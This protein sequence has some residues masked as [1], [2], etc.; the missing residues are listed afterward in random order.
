MPRASRSPSAPVEGSPSPS[1]SRQPARSL[2]KRLLFAAI[3]VGVLLLLLEG[4]ANVLWLLKDAQALQAD[5]DRVIGLK[6]DSHCQYD[7]EVGWVHIPGKHLEDFYGPGGSI[8]INDLGVRGTREIG[9]PKP[10]GRFRLVCLGDSFTLG[11]GVGD[12]ETFPEQLGQINAGLE[13]INMGQGG[14]SVGQCYLWYCQLADQL[15]AD[16]VVLT[17]IVADLLRLK[18]NRTINGYATPQFSLDRKGELVVSNIPVPQKLEVGAGIAERRKTW[19]L[20]SERSGLVR[21]LSTLT[22]NLLVR[23][24]DDLESFA[25]GI[26]IIRSLV[27]FCREQDQQVSLVL[28]PTLQEYETPGLMDVYHAVS[29]LLQDEAHAMAIPYRDLSSAFFDSERLEELFLDEEFHHYSAAGNRLVAEEL[30][31][32]LPTVLDG[33]PASTE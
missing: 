1:T 11:Y 31:A 18:I 4:L 33:Y 14:Y 30:N 2:G 7:P 23:E 8:S 27:R 13:T 32:W 10:D 25:I 5:A 22:G 9:T 12:E 28:L 21:T 16:A 17:I 19:S 29:T 6:E 24:P 26:E 20:I 3:A 15:D